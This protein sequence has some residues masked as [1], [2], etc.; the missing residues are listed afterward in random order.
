V[1]RT[2]ARAS[3]NAAI[4][5]AGPAPAIRTSGEVINSYSYGVNGPTGTS[6]WAR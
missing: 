1:T 4:D 6:R 3:T 2:P 5:P